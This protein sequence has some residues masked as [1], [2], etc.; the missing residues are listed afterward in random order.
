MARNATVAEQATLF[1]DSLSSCG[2]FVRAHGPKDSEEDD[3]Y[4]FVPY[5]EA[6]EPCVPEAIRGHRFTDRIL[7]YDEDLTPTNIAL[8]PFRNAALRRA[9]D[10]VH[11]EVCDFVST[12]GTEAMYVHLGRGVA[13]LVSSAGMQSVEQLT[14]TADG[15]R[16]LFVD[17]SK[18]APVPLEEVRRCWDQAGY[19]FA[20]FNAAYLAHLPPDQHGLLTSAEQAALI[21]AWWIGIF[22]GPF[23]QGR[24]ILA[25]TGVFG[26]GKSMTGRLLGTAF[27]GAGYE[28]SGGISGER[29][30]KDLASALCERPMVVRDDMNQV[31]D[32]ITDLLCRV[33]TG[34]TLELAA[35][36]ETLARVEYEM[37]GTLAIT[38]IRPRWALRE[39]LLS[40][41]LALRFGVP[42]P[43]SMTE[44]Q[45]IEIVEKSRT[46]IW[47]ETL[48][49]LAASYALGGSIDPQLGA[50]VTRFGDWER[51]VRRVAYVGGWLLPLDSALKKMPQQT[52]N[53]A[54]HTD[55]TLAALKA[56][57]ETPG[58]EDREFSASELYDAITVMLGSYI[59]EEIKDRPSFSVV[60]NPKS[61]GQFL[62]RIEAIGGAVCVVERSS[63]VHN[64]I[65]WR[66]RPKVRPAPP[67]EV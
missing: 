35:F 17:M 19:G 28:V 30:M 1:C 37:R 47:A 20:G 41:L 2:Q 16:L 57:A 34:A 43:S 38:S 12:S 22:L 56:L 14:K 21:L 24:P 54:A 50:T 31:P 9:R 26:S 51:W 25:L 62:S 27:N 4:W 32:E 23:V 13:V 64:A 11:A 45:R 46:W 63:R 59:T 29:A 52:V 3:G 33:A 15:R 42:A 58:V 53:L 40:R 36:H 44:S 61:M 66:V 18:F 8:K 48:K 67:V 39:D 65:R 6:G 49:A 7:E 10:G 55:P 60:R 5:A